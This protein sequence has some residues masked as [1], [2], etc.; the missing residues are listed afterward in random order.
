MDDTTTGLSDPGR[1][2]GT[3]A[4]VTGATRGIGEAVAVDLA[5][6]GC[7]VIAVGRKVE[8]L[9]ALDD[10]IRGVNGMATLVPIELTDGPGVDRLGA[11]IHERWGK[12]DIFVGNAG[13]LGRIAPLA[14][15]PAKVW[16]ETFDV[17]VSAN[18]RLIRTLDPVLRAATAARC[19]FLTSGAATKLRPNWGPYSISK[20]ALN[21]LVAT[22]AAEVANTPIRANLFS[23]GPIRTLMRAAAVP[24]EDPMTLPTPED[25]AP[26]IAAMC[27]PSFTRNG[28]TWS[29][30]E[31]DF[32]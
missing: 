32:V 4:V 23:P 20:A 18:W 12:L 2:D 16:Q 21:A 15:V 7:H 6:R 10:R 28:A 9:E 3:L 30:P 14:H 25:V 27:A 24:G 26:Y 29:F 19:V 31:R 13:L 1:L 22:Y 11:S 17:N 5:A 8:A